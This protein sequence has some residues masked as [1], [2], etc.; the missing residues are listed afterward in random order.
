MLVFS[1]KNKKYIPAGSEEISNCFMFDSFITF[2]EKNRPLR[3]ERKEIHFFA[4]SRY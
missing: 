1:P 2:L 4:A 3:V